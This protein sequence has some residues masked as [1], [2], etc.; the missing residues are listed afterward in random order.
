ME[1]LEAKQLILIFFRKR[2]SWWAHSK[3]ST[4]FW[5]K[6]IK[7]RFCWKGW[8]WREDGQMGV[9]WV[10]QPSRAL[11]RYCLQSLFGNSD[12][13]SK[14]WHY[15][16]ILIYKNQFSPLICEESEHG[17]CCLWDPWLGFGEEMSRIWWIP[18][19]SGPPGTMPS[20]WTASGWNETGHCYWGRPMFRTKTKAGLTWREIMNVVSSFHSWA[21]CH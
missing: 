15:D 7:M 1:Y 19:G 8:R 16:G 21:W 18:S 11:W 12:L 20:P 10:S 6:E 9:P 13:T 17:I 3:N 5:K 2:P 4:N 14:T